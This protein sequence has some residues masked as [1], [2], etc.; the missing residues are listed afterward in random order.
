MDDREV[1]EYNCFSSISSFG[2]AHTTLFPTAGFAGGFFARMKGVVT[3]LEELGANKVSASGASRQSTVSKAEAQRR[4]SLTLDGMNLA[5]DA[6]GETTPGFELKFR[7]PREK[8]HQAL[9]SAARAFHADA[10]GMEAEF[11]KYGMA[12]DFLAELAAEIADFEHAAGEHQNHEQARVAVTAGVDEVIEE[13][14]SIRRSLNAIVR[15]TL[16]D[17][18]ALLAAWESAN[19]I[20]RPARKPKAKPPTASASPSS[21]APGTSGAPATSD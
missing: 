7:R 16:R 10:Q 15:N 19:H 20:E 13:G 9:L 3:R 8:S 1:A 5:A 17:D 6:M 11:I 2:D 12:A 14:R 4:L 18:S 21:E